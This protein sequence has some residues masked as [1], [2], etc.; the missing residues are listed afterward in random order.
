MSR[1]GLPPVPESE[2]MQLKH[3]ERPLSKCSKR[4]LKSLKIRTFD[5]HF[6]EIHSAACNDAIDSVSPQDRAGTIGSKRRLLFAHNIALVEMKFQIPG[7]QF[8]KAAVCISTLSI[9]LKAPCCDRQPSEFSGN[10]ST[11]EMTWPPGE[12]QRANNNVVIP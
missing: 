6:Q 2:A 5:I 1:T 7:L 10:A 12:H 11:G 4:P 8:D 3:E 9:P